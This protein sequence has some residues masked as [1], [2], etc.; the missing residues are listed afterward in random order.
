MK[1]CQLDKKIQFLIQKNNADVKTLLKKLTPYEKEMK[2]ETPES[3]FLER[4][5]AFFND[6]N[7]DKTTKDLVKN[8]IDTSIE[9]KILYLFMRKNITIAEVT[10]L[11][12]AKG[13]DQIFGSLYNITP[14]AEKISPKKPGQPTGQKRIKGVNELCT[15]YKTYLENVIKHGHNVDQTKNKASLEELRSLMHENGIPF[16]EVPTNDHDIKSPTSQNDVKKIPYIEENEKEV[17]KNDTL[18]YQIASL[19]NK[20]DDFIKKK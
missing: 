17:R 20:I 12:L 18:S 1:T 5:I 13:R 8:I 3:S 7:T 16:Q 2:I 6:Q 19:F 10:N 11:S 14:F 4:F 15:K 9:T